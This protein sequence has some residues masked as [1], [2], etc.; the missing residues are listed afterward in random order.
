[1]KKV[2]GAPDN[3]RPLAGQADLSRGNSLILEPPTADIVTT[4]KDSTIIEVRSRCAEGEIINIMLGLELNKQSNTSQ[5]NVVDEAI[6]PSVR[7]LLRWGCG[8][9]KFTAECDFLLGT[10]LAIPAENISV[11]ARYLKNTIPWDPVSDATYPTFV[12]SATAAYGGIGRNSNPARFTELVQIED[13]AG[14]S[15]I[16]IPQFA[17][18]YSVLPVANGLVDVSQVGFGT[19]YNVD[20]HLSEAATVPLRNTNRN[21]EN[22]VPIFNG[23]RF[24]DVTNRNSEGPLFAFVIFGLAL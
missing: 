23:A 19:S 22:S 11:G 21:V 17:I 15:R 13:P 4:G 20:Y 3:R 7:A 16:Q 10:Q 1:M 18:S 6:Y 5:A 8:G 24:L 14:V 2:D 9:V 12:V